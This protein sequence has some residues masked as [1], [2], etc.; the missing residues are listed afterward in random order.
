[1]SKQKEKA[2]I[3][4]IIS[5]IQL[6]NHFENDPKKLKLTQKDIDRSEV[7]AGL[8]LE[9]DPEEETVTILPTVAFCCENNKKD[10]DIFGGTVLYK[11][12]IKNFDEYF[13]G[14]EKGKIAFLKE[15]LEQ[16]L[17]IALAG[18]R[19]MFVLLNKQKLYKKAY[20]PLID[21][22]PFLDKFVS[23]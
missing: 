2:Q 7:K 3:H 17:G 15:F 8:E 20:L 10:V 21:P 4:F 1:M 18:L 9:V 6:I 19:G 22:K 14:D 13:S 23:K 16:L 12:Q 5:D 11:F